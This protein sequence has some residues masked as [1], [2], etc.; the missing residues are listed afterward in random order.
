VGWRQAA[1]KGDEESLKRDLRTYLE[2][3]LPKTLEIK[4]GEIDNLADY[5]KPLIVHY[6]VKGTPGTAVGKRLVMP[7]DM[8]EAGATATFPHE[9]RELSVYFHYASFTLDAMRVR[10]SKA[11][12]VEA[13][14]DTAKLSYAGQEAYALEVSKDDSSYTMHRNHIQNEVLVSAK[15]YEALRKYYAQFESKDQ[16]SVVLKGKPAEQAAN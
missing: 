5:E 7:A 12:E 10:F 11:F 2:G 13:V 14:P 8:F 16:E 4:V 6:D 1:L 3:Q 15:D 9:K